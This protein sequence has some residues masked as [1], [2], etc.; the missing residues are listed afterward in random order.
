VSTGNQR[1][2]VSFRKQLSDGNYG[3]E[4]AEASIELD[5]EDDDWNLDALLMD[6]R[7]RVH[8]ELARSPSAAVRRALTPPQPVAVSPA[9]D[10]I[11]AEDLPF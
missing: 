10:D 9:N 3:S 4:T 5:V 1:M 2:R 6:V 11:G 8:A 7:A